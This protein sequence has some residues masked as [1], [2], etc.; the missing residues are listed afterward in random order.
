M[1]DDLHLFKESSGNAD[2]FVFVLLFYIIHMI[3]E[4][5]LFKESSVKAD[6]FDS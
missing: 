4:A 6:V 1:K 2:V 3:G 5:H